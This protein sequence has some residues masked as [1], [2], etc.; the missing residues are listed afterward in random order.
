VLDNIIPLN[1]ENCL[2]NKNASNVTFFN[3]Q[4][5]QMI[6]QLSPGNKSIANRVDEQS[7]DE[8]IQH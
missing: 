3:E 8:N 2:V 5:L 7:T 4:T 1:T 6:R